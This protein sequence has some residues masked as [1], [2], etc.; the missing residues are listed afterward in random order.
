MTA[1][2]LIAM[3]GSAGTDVGERSGVNGRDLRRTAS[4]PNDGHKQLTRERERVQAG[5]EVGGSR[6]SD[7]AG[8]NS[9][10]KGSHLAG[11][12]IHHV[13]HLNPRAIGALL[14]IDARLVRQLRHRVKRNQLA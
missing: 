3:A 1:C 6:S 13:H 9:G 8:A 7:T 2:A 10:A 5:A 12:R 4:P 14:F 11:L